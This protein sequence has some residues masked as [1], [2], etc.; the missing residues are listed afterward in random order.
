MEIYQINNKQHITMSITLELKP[1][2]YGQTVYDVIYI[3]QGQQYKAANKVKV[4][5]SPVDPG[6]R[7]E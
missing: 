2:L 6:D 4:M 3:V 1:W 5:A 7:V